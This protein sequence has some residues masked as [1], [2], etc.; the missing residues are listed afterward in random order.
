MSE[1]QDR[2]LE[3]RKEFLKL[4]IAQENEILKIY[5]DASKQISYK[6]C[7][8]KPGGLTS[9]Y[10]SEL[11][12]SIKDYVNE[13]RTNLSKSLKNG[14]EAS[15]QIASS[16]Q[17][18]YIDM[19][20][21]RED[22]KNTFSKM[23]T[24]LPKDITKQLIGS[25]YYSDGKTLDQRLWELTKSNSRAIDNLIKINVAKG[26]NARELA[27]QLDSYINPKN[28]MESK[29]LYMINDKG[30]KVKVPLPDGVSY[31]VSY[32]AR[33]LARTSLTHAHNESYIQ[34]SKMNP[35]CKGLKWN[36][37]PAHYER[38]HGRSDICDENANSNKYSLGQGV[39]PSNEY[40]TSHPNCLCYPTQENTPVDQARDELIDW[41]NGG[42]NSELDNW[43]K[44]FG[45][46]FGLTE[47]L[48]NKTSDIVPKNGYNNSKEAKEYLMNNLGFE[49][50]SFSGLKDDLGVMIT[51]KIEN[52]FNNFPELRGFINEIKVTSTKTAYASASLSYNRIE[53][54]M[55]ATLNI[56]KVLMGDM[57]TVNKYYL[58]D[59][60]AKFHPKG[61]DAESII[62]HELGHFIEFILNIK[63]GKGSIE[64]GINNIRNST[65][66]RELREETLNLCKIGLSDIDK[67]LSIY[68]R[69]N[70]AEFMAEAFA[71][72]MDSK[73]PRKIAKIFMKL[74]RTRMEELK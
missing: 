73:R 9:R 23:F 24:L 72:A 4:T 1:Y 42:E 41:L 38:M 39:Y 28:K 67:N 57:E 74:L 5:E 71:E 52:V 16:V 31:N 59:L 2:I 40:P 56:S 15:A 21:P 66:S 49:K 6:L 55:H 11:D 27:E 26:A 30:N 51:R 10:L 37:S 70:S 54:E 22:I 20:N 50:V 7:K 19:M 14:I 63:L 53:K 44:N 12:R 65:I 69:E 46:E 47:E 48:N 43:Y 3:A 8:A 62:T 25:N 34:G 64:D 29:P 61:T 13:V 35:F 58:R 33:R 17:A 18:S 36:L 60:K 68:A 32:Q 45:K